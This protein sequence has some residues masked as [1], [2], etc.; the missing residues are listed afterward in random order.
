MIK[1]ITDAFI[2]ESYTASTQL[3]RKFRNEL[4]TLPAGRLRKKTIRGKDRYYRYLPSG[5]PGIRGKESYLGK[6]K[7]VLIRQLARRKFIETSIPALEKTIKNQK[8]CQKNNMAFDPKEV[9]ASLP[10]AYKDLDYSSILDSGEGSRPGVWCKEP[11]EKCSLY[12]EKLIH[13]TQNGIGVRSKSESIIAGMLETYEIPFRY[14]ALLI[15]GAD[16]Y[17]PDFTILNPQDNQVIYWE[18]FGMVD[19][20]EYAESMIK[21]IDNYRK[22]GILQ[23]YNLIV[24]METKEVPLNARKVRNTIKAHLLPEHQ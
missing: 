22:H 13:I 19:N 9:A 11:Y 10:K 18:H 8:Q 16:R 17:Y 14:E 7:E 24:T 15:V 5:T 20:E 21:K 3:L 2:A 12:P 4:E 6:D 1:T 23:G